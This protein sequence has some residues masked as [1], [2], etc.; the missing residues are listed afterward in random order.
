MCSQW[1]CGVVW[2]DESSW[3]CRSVNPWMVCRKKNLHLET[4][5]DRKNRINWKAFLIQVNPNLGSLLHCVF[6]QTE[7]HTD[8]H[9]LLSAPL[10]LSV[11]HLEVECSFMYKHMGVENRIHFFFYK[12]LNNK[13]TFI[14][15]YHQFLCPAF[16]IFPQFVE[17]TFKLVSY[18]NV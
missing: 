12:V 15:Y 18:L 16:G 17:N 10:I 2:L 7:V 1:D 4:A 14:V 9:Y 3:I 11:N 6:Y 8:L 5:A 13:G